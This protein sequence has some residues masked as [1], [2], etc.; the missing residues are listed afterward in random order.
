[1]IGIYVWVEKDRA[2][3]NGHDCVHVVKEKLNKRHECFCRYR[4]TTVLLRVAWREDVRLF[5]TAGYGLGLLRVPCPTTLWHVWRHRTRFSVRDWLRLDLRR[6]CMLWMW[7]RGRQLLVV[8]TLV[9]R[10]TGRRLAVSGLMA[11]MHL[12][13]S[14]AWR[15]IAIRAPAPIAAESWLTWLAWAEW[16]RRTL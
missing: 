1:M 14:C 13:W 5:F 11:L 9:W 16:P 7:H 10:D 4:A 12:K 8:R 2:I 6:V 3:Q 15:Y